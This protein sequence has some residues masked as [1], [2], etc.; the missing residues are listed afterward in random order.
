MDPAPQKSSDSYAWTPFNDGSVFYARR[1]R[2][3]EVDLGLAWMM[4][5][6]KEAFERMQIGG[7]A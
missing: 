3:D 5:V 1:D 7:R 6:K 4:F 2:Y